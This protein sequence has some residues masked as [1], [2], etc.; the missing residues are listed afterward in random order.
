M[1]TIKFEDVWEKYNHYRDQIPDG[2]LILFRSIKPVGILISLSDGSYYTHAATCVWVKGRLQLQHSTRKG[3]HPEWMSDALIRGYVDFDV[4]IVMEPQES[5]DSALFKV[6][7]RGVKHIPY[8]I[9]GGGYELLRRLLKRFTPIN[10]KQKKAPDDADV[11]SIFL[12]NY[13]NNYSWTDFN[14]CIYMFPQDFVRN[15]NPNHLKKL[16]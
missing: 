5:I 4:W 3:V 13:F 6:L 7:E 14:G 8:D 2:A 10:L 12:R 1:G 16:T 9:E 11:C 15:L